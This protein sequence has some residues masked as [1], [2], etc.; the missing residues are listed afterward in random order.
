M[1]LYSLKRTTEARAEALRLGAGGGKR[2]AV[3]V[4]RVALAHG[5]AALADTVM[6]AGRRR[7]TIGATTALRGEIDYRIGR[8]ASALER[9]ELA[10]AAAGPA[11]R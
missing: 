10:T 6:A 7:T 3:R 4:A 5:D 1:A 2:T 8:Y 9:L 11:D